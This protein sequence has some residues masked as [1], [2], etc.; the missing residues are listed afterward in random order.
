[1][2]TG[3]FETDTKRAEK[4]LKNFQKTTSDVTRTLLALAPAL[5]VGAFAVWTKSIIEAGDALDKL[6]KRTGVAVKDLASLELIAKQ[7]D[8]S[9]ESLANGFNKI[10]RS[11]GEAEA[12]NKKLADAFRQLGVTSKDPI[13][14]FLQLSDAVVKSNDATKTQALL[15]QVLGRGYTELLPLL[16]E[17]REAIEG[18]TKASA[19]YA[20]QQAKFA[21]QAARFNDQLASL[22]QNLGAVGIAFLQESGLLNAFTNATIF[23][24]QNT[25]N[26][27]R[28]VK[29]LTIAIGALVTSK[30]VAVLLN[31]GVAARIAVAGIAALGIALNQN[32][33]NGFQTVVD[34]IVQSQNEVDKLQQQLDKLTKKSEVKQLSFLETNQVAN[35][36]RAIKAEVEKIDKERKKLKQILGDMAP[37]VTG[38][39]DNIF[40]TIDTIQT[41]N[42]SRDVV[43]SDNFIT[44]LKKEVETLGLNSEELKRYEAN[45]LK[46]T[47][48]QKLV[49]EALLGKIEAYK[50]EEQRLKAL[51]EALKEHDRIVQAS[52]DLELETLI[53]TQ[54]EQEVFQDSIQS[55]IDT[56][57]RAIDPTIELADN[58][59]KLQAALSLGLID[60]EQFEVMVQYLTDLAAKTQE[61]TD[62]MTQFWIQA[63]RNMQDA[64]SGFFFDIM[65]GNISDLAGSFKRTI[66][67]MVSDL[68]ASQLLKFL[69]GDFGTTGS[70]GGIL[71]G[72]IGRY[73]GGPVTSN[74]PYLVGERGPELFV[75]NTSGRIIDANTTSGMGG[76]VSVTNNFSVSGSV[77]TR[78]QS[79]IGSMV[80]MSVNRAIRRNT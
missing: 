12:G 19:Q 42:I 65:Q 35:L 26:L 23:A 51:D 18:S 5:T 7:S 11:I 33:E 37:S 21:P 24:T 6:S 75:P 48:T 63:A 16:K 47:D 64:M 17:G 4:S 14:S 31:L 50:Q 56:I 29:I 73:T 10:G 32:L 22:K 49:V 41:T 46:L 1:M 70:L 61:T 54:R 76:S 68:L 79:Q 20:E 39:Q 40:P 77:D 2:K 44:A 52:A 34:K 30:A 69:T 25:E 43:V 36:T 13:E 9:L 28:A 58:I 59:G 66:D 72:I 38:T 27:A 67:R 55:Y 80:G 15:A 74:S 60:N 3:S 8:T 45:Q 53:E 62:E 71:G 57:Q 78:T